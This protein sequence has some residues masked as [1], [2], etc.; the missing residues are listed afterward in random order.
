M[1][2]FCPPTQAGIWREQ[3]VYMK[4]AVCD[5]QDLILAQEMVTQPTYKW[6]WVA[7]VTLTINCTWNLATVSLKNSLFYKVVMPNVTHNV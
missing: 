2:A 4:R 3:F 5:Q 6:S 7:E 1:T